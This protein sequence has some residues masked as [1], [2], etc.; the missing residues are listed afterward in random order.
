MF[1]IALMEKMI[2]VEIRKK[3]EKC[4]ECH[5]RKTHREKALD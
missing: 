1:G 2:I 3:F 4:Q 5:Q